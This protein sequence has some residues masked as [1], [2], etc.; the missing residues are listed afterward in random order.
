MHEEDHW[1][2]V[3]TTSSQIEAEMLRDLLG[4]EGIVSVVRTSG[5]A[6]FLGVISP[7][8]LLVRQADLD[9]AAA[10]VNA[11]ESGSEWAED[12]YHD[13]QSLAEEE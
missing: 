4:S 1:T 9:T 2:E 11:W 6:P 8:R 13:E 3:A 12:F 5:A 10:F 7:C